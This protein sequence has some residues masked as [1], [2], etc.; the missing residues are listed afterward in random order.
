MSVCFCFPLHFSLLLVTSL[1]AMS[2]CKMQKP[3]RTMQ[4]KDQLWLA[5]QAVLPP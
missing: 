1:L 5:A 4:P 3:E 2:K